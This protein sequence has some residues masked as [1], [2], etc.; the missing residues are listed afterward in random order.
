MVLQ[1]T[2]SIRNRKT[3][4]TF[5]NVKEYMQV[6]MSSVRECLKDVRI[7]QLL[8]KGG[9]FKSFKYLAAL[10]LAREP[11]Y[12]GINAPIEGCKWLHIRQMTRAG[13]DMG[14]LFTPG[15]YTHAI[16]ELAK[17]ARRSDTKGVL[18]RELPPQE[19]VG[20]PFAI[21]DAGYEFIL[22]RLGAMSE[23]LDRRMEYE[24]MN[25]LLAK[26]PLHA[27]E[28]Y[29]AVSLAN[30]HLPLSIGRFEENDLSFPKDKVMSR[31]HA[32]VFSR[33]G[34]FWIEDLRSTNGTWKID[35]KEP[36]G[37]RRI[38]IEEINDNDEFQVGNTILRF[39][40]K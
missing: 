26:N 19:K 15:E 13:R 33:D 39:L 16:K 21:T 8:N 40:C 7:V 25:L 22:E 17:L 34:K 24:T 20:K 18:V 27:P 29:T 28:G 37:R 11:P 36:R 30:R 2:A 38:E 1:I 23:N 35:K 14:L 6:R 32:R 31:R 3:L 12:D 10:A 9:D 5:Q 4:S